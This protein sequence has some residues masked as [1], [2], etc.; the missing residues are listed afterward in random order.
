MP[1]QEHTQ[2]NQL[3][4]EHQ[5][6][7]ENCGIKAEVA[8]SRGYFSVTAL[9]DL[10]SLCFKRYQFT[11]PS[12]ISPIFGFDGHIVTYLGK[13]DRPRMRDGHPIEEELPEG[14]SLAID[15]P[16]AS[17]LS[18]EDSETE[19]W[20]TDGPRQADALTSVGLTAVGLIGHRGWRSLRPRKKKPLAAWDN[21]SLNGREVVIAFGSIAT[22][23]PDRLADLQ[24]FTRFL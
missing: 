11:G 12:L 13:P 16:P 23:T 18:L 24:H 10:T 21:T 8:K 6:L 22:S 7:L 19:L 2:K 3:L 5:Q 9:A 17:L 1:R 20:I 15:V 14:S 4:P